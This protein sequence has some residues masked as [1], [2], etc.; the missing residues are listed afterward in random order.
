M[1]VQVA[2]S[3]TIMFLFLES[4]PFRTFGVPYFMIEHPALFLGC[5]KHQL[6]ISSAFSCLLFAAI[7]CSGVPRRDSFVDLVLEVKALVML[8]SFLS[9]SLVPS[10]QPT[11]WPCEYDSWFYFICL[12][13]YGK[14]NSS[15]YTEILLSYCKKQYF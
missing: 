11:F 1:L 7:T 9:L 3:E 10:P 8:F 4:W 15:Y 5:R 14:I 13:D 12:S 2:F 6:I